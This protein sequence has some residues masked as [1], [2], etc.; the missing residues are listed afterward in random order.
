MQTATKCLSIISLD[1]TEHPKPKKAKLRQIILY[2]SFPSVLLTSLDFDILQPQW[3]LFHTAVCVNRI[4][5]SSGGAVVRALASHQSGPG[6]IPASGVIRCG[7]KVEL[8]VGPLLA[9]GGF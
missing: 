7:Y 9:P 8:V 2:S 5:G 1:T 4:K 3:F 6:S